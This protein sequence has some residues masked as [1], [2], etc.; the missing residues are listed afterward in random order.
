MVSS[1]VTNYIGYGWINYREYKSK[2]D[3]YD[4]FEILTILLRKNLWKI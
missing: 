4:V 3:K 1:D 2:N